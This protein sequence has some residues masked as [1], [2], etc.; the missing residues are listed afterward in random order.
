MI[1][2]LAG[3]LTRAFMLAQRQS[4]CNNHFLR[5]GRLRQV[6]KQSFSSRSSRDA[7]YSSSDAAWIAVAAA[8]VGGGILV[9]P[10]LQKQL[11]KSSELRSSQLKKLKV[12]E[13]GVIP[14]LPSVIP[15]LVVGG[16]AAAFA[17]VRSIRANDPKA[18]VVIMTEEEYTPYM[19]PP[20]TKEI[21]FTPP[22]IAKTLTFRQFDG[23]DR[24]L[25]FEKEEFYFSLKR[26]MD[27]E[28]GGVCVLTKQRVVKIDA[29]KQTA[30]LQNGQSVKY[31]KCL[32]ATGGQAKTHPVFDAAPQAVKD[33]V[34]L[35]RKANDFLKLHDIIESSSSSNTIAIIGGGFLGSELS[36]SLGRRSRDASGPKI[37]QTF[38]E[39]GNLSSVLPEYLSRWVTEKVRTESVTVI[40]EVDVTAVKLGSKNRLNITLSNGN[41]IEADHAVVAIGLS[42]SVDIA[43]P[44]G[45]ETHMELGGFVVNSELEARSNLWVAGDASCFYDSQLQKRRRVE[46]HDHA[47]VTGR[48][49][50]EN[51]TGAKKEYKIQSMFWSDLGSDIGFEAVGHLDSSLKTIGFFKQKTSEDEKTTENDF[52]RGVVFYL[53]DDNKIQG[54]LMWN[55]FNRVRLARRLIKDRRSHDDLSEVAKLFNI[56]SSDE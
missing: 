20:L 51:M 36:C 15:Y 22:E 26:L 50:G 35:Y 13:N 14:D 47:I 17:A 23:K 27:R 54:I 40:P 29:T 5:P 11:N 31:E 12:Q 18:K 33:R 9:M 37:I 1:R 44:S 56:Y 39:K 42:P 43:K 24:P 10:G 16:G 2:S 46:H 6:E 30:F 7:G 38:P 52:G 34:I 53:N 49:V 8:V 28:T 45:L 19:K 3:S 55:V 32:L 21:W 41:T 4:N 48:L 25:A